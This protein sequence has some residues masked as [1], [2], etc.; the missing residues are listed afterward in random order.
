MLPDFGADHFALFGLPRRFQLE[1]AGLESA[2]KR[3]LAEVHPDRFA[4]APEATRRASVQWATRVN[5]AYR[6]LKSPLTRA[7]YL[8][9]LQGIHSLGEAHTRFPPEFLMRQMAWRESL[10]DAES[11]RDAAA[12]RH[13]RDEIRSDA[14]ILVAD[15]DRALGAEPDY[16]RGAEL[17][18]ELKFL[19]K[20]LYEIDEAFEGVEA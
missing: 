4:G 15:L 6:T 7:D 9:G 10:L 20:L 16:P 2:Y 1:P 5:E 17:V 19:E 12:L 13:L 8:L 3:V 11:N 18:R 14:A